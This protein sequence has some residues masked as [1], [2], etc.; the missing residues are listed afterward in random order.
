MEPWDSSCWGYGLHGHG[1][2]GPERACSIVGTIWEVFCLLQGLPVEKLVTDE[3]MM[4]N[5]GAGCLKDRPDK[6]ARTASFPM[7]TCRRFIVCHGAEIREKVGKGLLPRTTAT[8][9]D[10]SDRLDK[11]S[12]VLKW[13]ADVVYIVPRRTLLFCKSRLTV[14]EASA[15]SYHH[16]S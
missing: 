8:L 14:P 12:P 11:L 1:A 2:L 6:T 5:C 16:M 15:A 10:R 9:Q 13:V 3:S 7:S 4:G